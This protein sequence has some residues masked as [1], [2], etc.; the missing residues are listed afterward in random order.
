VDYRTWF[1]RQPQWNQRVVPA[2]PEEI[3]KAVATVRVRL[4]LTSIVP[5]E[6]ATQILTPFFEAG[7]CLAALEH[8]W[9]WRP[10]GTKQYMNRDLDD[11][12][13]GRKTRRWLIVQHLD[14]WT[15][16]SGVPK[17]PPVEPVAPEKAYEVQR[18]DLDRRR[19]SQLPNAAAHAARRA[20][21]GE[22]RQEADVR[23]SRRRRDRVGEAR[24]RDRRRRES[25][26]MLADLAGLH[27]NDSVHTIRPVW[28]SEGQKRQQETSLVGEVVSGY[29]DQANRFRERV[30]TRGQAAVTHEELQV[31][32]SFRRGAHAE[33]DLAYLDRLIDEAG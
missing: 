21:V 5:H 31:L 4:G 19:Q 28:R 18:L 3:D 25:L 1:L 6:E 30:A 24:E 27:D 2:S 8:A 12:T 7:W 23:Q 11:G 17:A 32:K 10:N 33:G 9:T 22:S 20:A 13:G 26:G 16:K 14:K 29:L 15:D